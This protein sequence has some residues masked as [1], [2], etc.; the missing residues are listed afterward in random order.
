MSIDKS[1]VILFTSNGMG[2]SELQELRG[3]LTGKFLRLLKES[4]VLPTAICFYTDGVKLVCEGSGVLRELTDLEAQGVRLV[5]CSTC[6][7][8]Y[9]LSGSTRVGIVGG[10]ADILTAMQMADSVITVS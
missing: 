10:M 1:L 2:T 6:L 8:A 4:S 5:I 9:G 7:D 3:E